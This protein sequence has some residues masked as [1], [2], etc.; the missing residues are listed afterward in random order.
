MVKIE[1]IGNLGANVAV[2]TGQDGKQYN[3]FQVAVTQ[4]GETQ[5]FG[6]IMARRERMEQYLTRGQKVYI[7]GDLTV[8]F[9]TL[10]DGRNVVDFDVFAKEI[11]L[12]GGKKEE[13]EGK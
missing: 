5:W 1:L 3:A 9:K 2:R 4:N 13:D 8:T 7:R 6:I 12:V 10:N 11:E